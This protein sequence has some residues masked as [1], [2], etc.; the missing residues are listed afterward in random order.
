V[1][2][3]LASCDV[4]SPFLPNNAFVSSNVSVMKPSAPIR[5]NE[6]FGILFSIR[7]KDD[8]ILL[9]EKNGSV[10]NSS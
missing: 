2:I 4:V 1:Y 7:A 8:D 9:K 3:F 5:T 10:G 6:V